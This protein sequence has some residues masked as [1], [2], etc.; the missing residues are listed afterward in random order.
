MRAKKLLSALSVLVVAATVSGH[1]QSAAA[2]TYPIRPGDTLSQ[3]A[4]RLGVSVQELAKANGIGDPNLIIA[5]RMLVVPSDGG[6]ATEYLVRRGDTLSSI[7]AKVGVP[8]RDLARANGLDN[9][10]RLP[11]GRL[12][13]IP[14]VGA[15]A[16]GTMGSR[17]TYTVKKGDVLS[18]IALKVG[19][20]PGQLAAANGIQNLDLIM[21][22]QI[23]VVPNVWLC[24]V[25]DASFVN[26]YGYVR[27]DGSKHEGIDMFAPRG[28]PIRAPVSGRVERFPNNAGGNAVHLYSADGTRY[29]FGHL[30][31]YGATGEVTAG[32]VIGYVGNSGDAATT[33]THLH[34]EIHPAGGASINPFPSLVAACR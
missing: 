5:G 10:N 9:P 7:S 3:L 27:G 28:S 20:P 19:V 2:T 29:Y 32:T 16:A 22:D 25:P 8:V 15:R 1:D 17:R 26:D 18:V 11:A 12:L 30:D 24:P 21:A 13:S 14:P 4:R 33:S 6:S 34:F 31:S 23:L